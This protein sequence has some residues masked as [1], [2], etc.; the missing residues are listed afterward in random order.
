MQQIVEV[1]Q[2]D[3]NQGKLTQPIHTI[4]TGCRGLNAVET[5]EVLIFMGFMMSMTNPNCIVQIYNHQYLKLSEVVLDLSGTMFTG[6]SL[7]L[8]NTFLI[9]THNEGK[10]SVINLEQSTSSIIDEPFGR[11]EN[12]W[13][14]TV[15]NPRP[16][17]EPQ[18]VFVPSTNGMFQCVVTLQGHFMYC[19]ESFFE[20]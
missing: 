2:I 8:D 14:V 4:T 11:V 7:C 16:E 19:M 1:Y 9:G 17:G 3:I 6:L 10:I 20:G 15:F 5:S 18:T 12:I 13:G